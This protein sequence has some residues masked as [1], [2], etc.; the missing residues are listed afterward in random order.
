MT[1]RTAVAVFAALFSASPAQAT[2]GM[3]MIGFGPV[4]NSMGGVG[5]GLTLDSAAIVTNPAGIAELGPRLDIGIGIFVPKPSHNAIGTSGGPIPAGTF[6]LADGQKFETTRGPSPI[7]FIGLVL[8]ITRDLTAGVSFSAVAGMGVTYDANLYGSTT[9]TNYM[10]ARLAPAIAYKFAGDLVS[11]GISLNIMYALMDWDV[12]S[13]FGQQPHPRAGALGIGGV[14]GI[15]VRPDPMISIGAAYETPS[16]FSDFSWD[17]A[18]HNTALGPLPAATDKLTFNQPMTAT[19]GMALT[20]FA[21]TDEGPLVIAADVVWINWS[22]T[23]GVNKP[24]F[25]ADSIAPGSGGMF[26]KA[27]SMAWNLS[28]GN[29]WV[30]KVGAQV[31]ATPSVKL[32]L[33]YNYGKNPLDP[34]RAFESIA[35]PAVQ[36]HHITAGVGIAASEGLTIN[37]GGMYAPTSS[38]SGSNPTPPFMGSNPPPY[39]QGIAS[40]STRMYQWEVDAGIAYRF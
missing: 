24:Q 39:G 18:A 16:W 4:Q 11:A 3:R 29:Q 38:I 27:G 34:N 40:F 14:V 13:A 17:I 36:E 1:K 6:I 7:P 25:T 28:W 32:R 8:P 35:F 19:V 21:G 15:K 37:L 23:N 26:T 2:N 12:A 30:F 10:Q 20:P 5:V 9:N 22:D 33:G 31:A